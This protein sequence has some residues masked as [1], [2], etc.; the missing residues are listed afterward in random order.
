VTEIR[1]TD[2][3]LR[4]VSARIYQKRFYLRLEVMKCAKNTS[5][6]RFRNLTE[7]E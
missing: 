4:H 7:N 3:V 6:K 1:D 5:W 2:G